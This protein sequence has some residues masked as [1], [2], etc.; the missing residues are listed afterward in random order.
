M[1]NLNWRINIELNV[2]NLHL[3]MLKA[4][5]CMKNW[6]VSVNISLIYDA[7]LPYNLVITQHT[8]L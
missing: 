3:I 1:S 6:S 5:A 2:L 7:W 4:I 8:L